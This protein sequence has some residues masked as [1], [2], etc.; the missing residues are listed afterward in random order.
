MKLAQGPLRFTLFHRSLLMTVALVVI[1]VV[2]F[3]V[4]LS[5]VR[6]MVGTIEGQ[7]AFITAQNAA[8]KQ[9]NTLVH[10]QQD[11][12]R[13]QATTFQAY[14]LYSKYLYWR[15]NA[16]ASGD[17]Q[18]VSEGDKA[19]KALRDKLK[20]IN[21]LS[22]DLGEAADA[23]AIYLDDFN[24]DIKQAYDLAQSG[25]A[26]NQV[27]GPLGSAQSQAVAM[28]SMFDSILSEASKAANKASSGVLD[29]GNKLADGGGRGTAVQRIGEPPR[30]SD[31]Q[32][33][34]VVILAVA[35]VASLIIGWLLAR[36]ISRPLQRL[37]RVIVD[38]E[39]TN[40]LS[41]R[42]HY[43]RSQRDRRHR[44]GLQQHAAQIRD[45]RQ[46]SVRGHQSTGRLRQRQC[47]GQQLN[48]PFRPAV[49]LRDRPGC[50]RQQ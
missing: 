20:A 18:S 38:I 3:S 26:P 48:R 44:S 36:S 45:H 35:L 31:L 27:A 5:N 7:T 32:Q 47:P 11:K 25:A 14:G 19:E 40:D 33:R 6:N 4:V 16:V 28:N 8:I 50:H 15:L 2:A 1:L 23:V 37:A 46:R 22:P 41:K 39:N 34:I 24:K 13:L 17:S 10:Q 29:M 9:Q 21:D 43:N 49:A 12:L 42:V 30:A